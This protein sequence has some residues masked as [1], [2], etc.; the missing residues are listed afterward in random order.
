MLLRSFVTLLLLL[1]LGKEVVHSKNGFFLHLELHG[2]RP[3]GLVFRS[4]L[5]C[6][7]VHCAA[8]REERLVVEIVVFTVGVASLE[9][10]C[11]V[12]ESLVVHEVLIGGLCLS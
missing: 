8:V 2:R 7:G 10:T 5:C 9:S 4:G 3:Y 6:L 11:V 1:W 12:K